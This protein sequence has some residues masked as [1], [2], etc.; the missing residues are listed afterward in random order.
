MLSH[1]CS[2]LPRT[3]GLWIIINWS[4]SLNIENNRLSLIKNG[5]YC[6]CF[7]TLVIKVTEYLCSMWVFFFFRQIFLQTKSIKVLSLNSKRYFTCDCFLSGYGGLKKA[8][9]AKLS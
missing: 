7:P 5:L 1:L 8:S 4:V 3:E 9:L 6:Y 2:R